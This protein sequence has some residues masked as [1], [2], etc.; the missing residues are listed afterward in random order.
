[1]EQLQDKVMDQ[2][3]LLLMDKVMDQLKLLLMLLLLL[4]LPK[5]KLREG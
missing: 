5:L 4:L 3:M 2:L 1:M